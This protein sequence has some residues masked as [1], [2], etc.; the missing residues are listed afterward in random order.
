MRLQTPSYP[1][2]VLFF[3]EREAETGGETPIL[4]STC[5]YED[6]ANAFPSFMNNL[7]THGVQYRRLMTPHDRP[8]S[9]IGRGWRNTFGA[10]TRAEVESALSSRGYS[11]E[12]RDP[13]AVHRV[14]SDADESALLLEMSPRLDAVKAVGT[15]GKKKAFFNQLLAVWHGWKDEFN[16]PEDCVR[17]A[18]GALLDKKAMDEILSVG[19]LVAKHTVAIPWQAGMLIDGHRNSMNATLGNRG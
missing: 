13:A 11:W 15:D 1:R 9:A 12:W 18:N 14:A 17:F 5:L 2:R 19:G 7:E 6:L 8:E 4:D 3:C 16:S 10:E